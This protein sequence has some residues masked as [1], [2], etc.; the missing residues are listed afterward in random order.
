M[1]GG[2]GEV[3]F[4]SSAAY[5]QWELARLHQRLVLYL[6]VKSGAQELTRFRGLALELAETRRRGIVARRRSVE[7][8]VAIPFDA[9]AERWDLSGALEDVVFACVAPHLSVVLADLYAAALGPSSTA[10]TVGLLADLVWPGTGE[11]RIA[12]LPT[13]ARR[14]GARA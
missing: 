11:Q 13:T 1:V 6:E 7:L 4:P 2:E 8:G 14:S 12:R 3:A 9:L 5:V 10:P